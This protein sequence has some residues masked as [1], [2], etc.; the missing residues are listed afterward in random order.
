MK[1]LIVNSLLLMLCLPWAARAQNEMVV[2]K[3][4]A[5]VDNYIV[6][7]SELE[8][9]Y[10]QALTSGQQLSP[11]ERC[12]ILEQLIVNKIMVTK[13]EIDSV[14]LEDAEIEMELERRMQY[15][16]MQAGSQ[17]KL[18]QTLGT[19]VTDLKEDLRDQ[20]REQLLTQRM[21]E[22]IMKDIKITPAQ[23]KRFFNKIPKDSI[24]FLPAEVEVAQIVMYPKVSR[25]EKDKVK[26]RLLDLKQQIQNGADFGELAKKNS[27]DYGSATR[28]GELGWHGRGELVPEFEAVALS[29]AENEIADPIESDFGFHLIQL[30]ERI[31]SRFR[32][33]HI[34]IRPKSN[35]NDMIRAIEVADS[36][37]NRILM[38]SMTFDVAAREHSEDQATR[39][40]A[41]FFK[42]ANTNSRRI[43]TDDLDPNIFFIVDTMKVGQV[44][45]PIRFRTEDGKQAVRMVYYHSHVPPHFANLSDDYQ[46]LHMAA[47]NERKRARLY[48]WLKT[49]I[50]DVFI[51]IDPEYNSCNLFKDL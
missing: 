50:K 51:D 38:D 45:K 26:A 11:N 5:K 37:R 48:D 31:G 46:K 43:A 28:G 21:Q 3:I 12:M 29:I 17:E 35:E 22:E 24:P 23:V 49:A 44:S 25:A 7:K 20:V 34:L 42:D 6:L 9:A 19:S 40:N 16:V 14:K 27:E 41:G 33:R 47:M 39:S 10:F 18:E 30:Q 13:A 2:D 4:I 36:I 15:F 32:A 8:T 1:C